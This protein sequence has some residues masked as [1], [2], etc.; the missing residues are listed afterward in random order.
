[1]VTFAGVDHVSFTVSDLDASQQFYTE[2]LDFLPALDVGY[3]R[4]FMHPRTGFTL[5]LI[6]HDGA[7]GGPFSELTTGLD[8]LGLTAASRDELE[9][10]ELR[11][12]EFGVSYTPIRDMEFGYHLN[13]RDPDNTALELSS[14][15]SSCWR[16]RRRSQM[17]E[18][19][20]PTSPPSWRTTSSTYPPLGR[21]EHSPHPRW[22]W[23][24]AG[25]PPHFG[26]AIALRL[27]AAIDAASMR[28]AARLLPTGCPSDIRQWPWRP[29]LTSNA[30]R[31]SCA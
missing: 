2:V 29:T 3:G 30:Q 25:A 19:A 16:P 9:E 12:D 18:Q 24:G 23:D 26:G 13:F 28:A 11:F 6:K 8:H 22:S 20:R 21:A 27:T 15:T 1:M 14:P 17:A 7:H 10:W 4:I 31:S 5:S